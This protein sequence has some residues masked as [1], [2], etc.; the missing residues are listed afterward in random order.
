MLLSFH[1]SLPAKRLRQR[2]PI[3]H[4]TSF[5]RQLLRDKLFHAWTQNPHANFFTAQDLKEFIIIII[6]INC[7]Y[8]YFVVL[9]FSLSRHPTN[10]TLSLKSNKFCGNFG[11]FWYWAWKWLINDISWILR[12]D[13]CGNMVV[14]WNLLPFRLQSLSLFTE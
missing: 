1:F 12:L 14:I 2:Y 11:I 4:S 7:H 6:S 5:D 3:S 10:T 8:Y 13:F 9:E